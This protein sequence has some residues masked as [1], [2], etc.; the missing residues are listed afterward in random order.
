MKSNLILA[1]SNVAGNVHRCPHGVVHIHIHGVSL[2]LTE[3]VFLSFASMVKDA[4]SRLINEH[5]SDLIK[6]SEERGEGG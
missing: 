4:S 2:H 3:E 1:K 6:D 5:L